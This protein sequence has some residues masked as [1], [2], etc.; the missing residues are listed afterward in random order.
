MI[1]IVTKTMCTVSGTN[2]SN[3]HADFPGKTFTDRTSMVISS[4]K[5]ANLS[6]LTAVSSPTP[7]TATL[8]SSST[9]NSQNHHNASSSLDFLNASFVSSADDHSSLYGTVPA[10]HSF[11]SGPGL[12]GLRMGSPAYKKYVQ[13]K[14]R[15]RRLKAA[16]HGEQASTNLGVDRKPSLHL[17]SQPLGI[18]K[19]GL[20]DYSVD[21]Y[22]LAS[23]MSYS[24]G[25]HFSFF[26]VCILNIAFLDIGSCS[27][28]NF[29]DS[30]LLL[31]NLYTVY[32]NE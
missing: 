18:V 19:A 2:V 29:N 21:A 8:L 3:Y 7:H 20:I 31:L 4:E 24:L 14:E 26:L 27:Y 30:E 5:L 13:L 1:T 23:L 6:P 11:A 17:M 15:Q 32:Y 16:Q 25:R 9:I 22:S 12:L 10:Y 28:T